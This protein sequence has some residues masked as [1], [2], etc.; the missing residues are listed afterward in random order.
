MVTD[1]ILIGYV[2]M[3]F[4][5]I[6]QMVSHHF[7]TRNNIKLKNINYNKKKIHL[8]IDLLIHQVDLLKKTLE[9]VLNSNVS[10]LELGPAQP[11]HVLYIL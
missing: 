10:K 5:I 6:G 9:T 3:Q 1:I 11:Q 8:I 2:I 7:P 4:I